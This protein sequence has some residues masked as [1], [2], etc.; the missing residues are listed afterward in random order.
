MDA[1]ANDIVIARATITEDAT[2]DL[3]GTEFNA[4]DVPATN[5]T[6]LCPCCTG[7]TR[8]THGLDILV[9]RRRR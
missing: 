3:C 8:L 5:S 4:E 2:C 7:S 6:T 1:I 9:G